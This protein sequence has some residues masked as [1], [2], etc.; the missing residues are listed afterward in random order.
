MRFT[1]VVCGLLTTGLL[2][3]SGKPAPENP[4]TVAGALTGEDKSAA[5]KNPVCQL[6]TPG[7]LQRYVGEPLSPGHSAAMGYGCQ[8]MGTSPNA[9][10]MIEV[11]PAKYHEPHKGAEGF[12]KVTDVGN[13]GFVEMSLG[14]WNA[15][16]IDGDKT[17]VASVSG[18][19]AS[20]A[21]A[22]ALLKEAIGRRAAKR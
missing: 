19:A 22:I 2:A 14:G 6:F 9:N 8:W 16:A 10:A 17:V 18:P 5:D 1:T 20:D 21:N 3:C 12:R 13:D 7:E 15:G 11:A 4:K